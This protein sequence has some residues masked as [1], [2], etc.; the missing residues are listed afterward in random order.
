MNS[1]RVMEPQVQHEI[2]RLLA[3]GQIWT[4]ACI[5]RELRK[6]L[7]LSPADRATAN[8]RPNEG[9]WEEL[10]NNALSPS[11]SNSLTARRYAETVEWG[12]HRITDAG[13]KKLEDDDMFAAAFH[14]AMAS[15]EAETFLR[16]LK[17]HH[18]LPLF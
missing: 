6:A 15:P 16:K 17:G 2:L 5:K 12:H 1:T 11:R 7:P 3:G 4:N 14:K 18:N 9:K 13:R 8:C 10:V